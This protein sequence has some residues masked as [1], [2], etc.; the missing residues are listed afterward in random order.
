MDDL[1]QAYRLTFRDGSSI[2]AGERYLWNVEYIWEKTKE[3]LW[4]MGE[5]YE[6]SGIGYGFIL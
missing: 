5:I 4:T 2:V 3:K 1:E 6:K